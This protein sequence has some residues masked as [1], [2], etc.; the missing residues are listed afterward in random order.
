LPIKLCYAD[1]IKPRETTTTGLEWIRVA[2][3]QPDADT[4][5]IDLSAWVLAAFIN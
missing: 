2:Q 1:V 4:E 5:E 3:L